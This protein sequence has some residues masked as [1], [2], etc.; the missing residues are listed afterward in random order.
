MSAKTI[1]IAEDHPAFQKLLKSILGKA[2][3]KVVVAKDGQEGLEKARAETP[4]M[5]LVD[6]KMPRLNGYELVQAVRGEPALARVPIIM[7]STLSE[8]G[9]IAKGLTLGADDYL[10]KPFIPKEVLARVRALFRQAGGEPLP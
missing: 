5:M 6:I 4:D 7:V 1:L 8:S 9:Q 10:T 2:G 3:Y